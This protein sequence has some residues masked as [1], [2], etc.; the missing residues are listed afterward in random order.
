MKKYILSG[1]LALTLITIAV[2]VFAES[3][4]VSFNAVNIE[5]NKVPVAVTGES[6]YL[7]NG[8]MVPY[9]I[10]Y[11]GTTYLPMR[12]VGELVG[13]E[14][15]YH[16]EAKTA[17]I[18]TTTTMESILPN[19]TAVTPTPGSKENINFSVNSLVINVDGEIVAKIG[20]SYTVADGNKVPF[21]LLYKGTTYLPMRKMGELVDKEVAYNSETKIAE[22]RDCVTNYEGF[23]SV[24]N[25]GLISDVKPIEQNAIKNAMATKGAVTYSYPAETMGMTD[26]EIFENH[27]KRNGFKFIENQK[28]DNLLDGADYDVYYNEAEKLSVLLG[29]AFEKN[30]ETMKLFVFVTMI[31]II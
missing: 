19:P 24:P 10:L 11:K 4:T 9:S 31:P 7:E 14:I 13:K 6:Y 28:I 15:F 20:E 5:V 29:T 30:R 8:N 23:K 22:I 2:P 26:F 27:L 21:S 16:D 12:K 17:S 1:L 25:F 18:A 3:Q